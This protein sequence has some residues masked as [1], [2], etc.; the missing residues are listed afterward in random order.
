MY[1]NVKIL[2]P[3]AH[4]FYRYTA[5]QDYYF[6]KDTNLIPITFSE[7]KSLCCSYPIIIL[8]QN[9][10]LMLMLMKGTEQNAA[11]DEKGQWTCDYLPAFLRRYPFTL[12][13]EE[14]G[15]TLQLGF[16]LDGG[17]FSSPD[18][19]ALFDT[20]GN[21]S[22]ALLDA[23]SLLE[24][25]NEQIQITS[26]ILKKLQERDILQASQFTFKKEGEE[27]QS[28]GGFFVIDREKLIEQD[29]AFLLDA[30]KNGWME[31]IELH[32]LS[33]R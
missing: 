4:G 1:H 5:P 23:K 28:I 17:C 31:M 13:A 25:Y 22:E 29:D 9:D 32:L 30:M 21:P 12:V 14:E 33:I 3:Q 19:V 20:E 27:D 18:G 2:Q 6:A 15:E 7:V 16:D 10:R 26:A 24:A 11:I 8:E